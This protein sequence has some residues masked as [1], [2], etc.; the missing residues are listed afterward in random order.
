MGVAIGI[1]VCGYPSW[2]LVRGLMS[3]EWPGGPRG[4]ITAG[5]ADRPLAIPEAHNRI[6]ET[7]L[8]DKRLDWLLMVDA[9]ATLHPQTLLRLLSWN[10]PVVGALCFSR[11]CP[12]APTIYAGQPAGAPE[13]YY[14]IHYAE[15]RAWIVAHPELLSNRDAV[16]Q[17]RPDD[18]LTPVDFTGAHCLLV[19]RDVLEAVGAPWFRRLTPES[20]A[21]T[22]ADRYFCERARAAGFPLYVDRS[23]V[24]GHMVGGRCIGALDFL[25]WDAV[26]DWKARRFV[27]AP[28]ASEPAALPGPYRRETL[29]IGEE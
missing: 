16:L 4:F 5:E 23:V 24:S 22:G 21:A 28:S 26:T 27:V 14:R 9:D 10:Q 13:G 20:E 1:P 11:Y 25:A 8:S 15:T 6:I 29:T 19:R 7:F 17:P 3:L 12:V 2:Q 18:A